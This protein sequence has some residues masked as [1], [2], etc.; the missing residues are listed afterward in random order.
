MKL[1][2]FLI[3][4]S[5]TLTNEFSKNI[6]RDKKPVK[7]RAQLI[8]GK[9]KKKRFPEVFRRRAE[10]GVSS[11]P[12]DQ[13]NYLQL[14][15]SNCSL[16]VWNVYNQDEEHNRS[17]LRTVKGRHYSHHLLTAS[18]LWGQAAS[19]VDNEVFKA[20]WNKQPIMWELR[21]RLVLCDKRAGQTKRWLMVKQTKGGG[22]GGA[23][24]RG[25]GLFTCRRTNRLHVFNLSNSHT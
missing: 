21:R 9:K 17:L 3:K 4:E 12:P 5:G 18:P 10:Q 24:K 20:N 16:S 15:V 8:K 6:L 14:S 7:I 11:P 13:P 25:F 19:R 22:G 23:E 1:V 2:E